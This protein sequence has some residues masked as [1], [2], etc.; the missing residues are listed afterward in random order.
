MYSANVRTCGSSS[1]IKTHDMWE[2]AGRDHLVPLDINMVAGF[3]EEAALVPSY[4][5]PAVPKGVARIGSERVY[6]PGSLLP[7]KRIERATLPQE[8]LSRV[9]VPNRTA[10]VA[11]SDASLRHATEK[12]CY[13]YPSAAFAAPNLA[14]S[15][16]SS[17]SVATQ[18]PKCQDKSIERHGNIPF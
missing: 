1:T 11:G 6:L 10:L 15:T 4:W 7:R 13:S 12:S 9:G 18:T 16:S 14:K 8:D 5:D 2:K 3:T 17:L